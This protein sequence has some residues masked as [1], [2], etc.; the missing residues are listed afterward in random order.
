MRGRVVT[1]MPGMDW[2][3]PQQRRRVMQ[4][5]R[6]K[7]TG[8]EMV[9]RRMVH[10]MGFRYRLHRKDLPGRPDLVFGPRKK[11]IF[12]NGC[13]WHAHNCK[14]GRMPESRREYWIPKLTANKERDALNVA[15]LEATGWQV[16]TVWE[17]EIRDAEALALR[18]REF[19]EECAAGRDP[20]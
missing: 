1:V 18:L 2:M 20:P 17:C 15:K 9:V 13:F 12:V 16:L 10:G 3:T 4:A 7:D 14:Y 19:L 5:I 6:S 8:P 11:A